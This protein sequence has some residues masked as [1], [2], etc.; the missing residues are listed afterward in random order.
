M[1]MT[2]KTKNCPNVT[3]IS[4]FLNQCNEMITT[5]FDPN[6]KL[7]FFIILQP[8]TECDKCCGRYLW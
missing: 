3:I 2:S 4:I 7:K 8:M 1:R 6:T 5:V